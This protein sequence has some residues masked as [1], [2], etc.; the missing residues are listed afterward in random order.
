MRWTIDQIDAIVA[1]GLWDS[2]AI[3]ITFDDWGGWFDHVEP[4]VKEAW[5][6]SHAQRPD[7][8]HPE[9]DGEPFRY[10]SRV[11]CLAIGPYAKAAHVSSQENSHVSIPKFCET[12]FGLNALTDRDA[13]ANGMADCFD[14]SQQPLEPPTYGAWKTASGT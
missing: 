5:D 10:G 1:G 2:C 3:F 9:F 13:Q 11:P 7:D 6:S 4:P 14:V 8:A 12:V